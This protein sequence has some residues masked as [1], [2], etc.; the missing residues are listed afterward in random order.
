LDEENVGFLFN[1]FTSSFCSTTE[2][3][4]ERTREPFGATDL[5]GKMKSCKNAKENEK[6]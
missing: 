5:G 1:F 3:F 2:E 4:F 6:S